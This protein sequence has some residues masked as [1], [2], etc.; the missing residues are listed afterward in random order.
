VTRIPLRITIALIAFG[1]LL[2]LLPSLS[3]AGGTLERPHGNKI[4][5]ARPIYDGLWKH[6]VAPHRKRWA[7]RVAECESGRNPDALSPGGTYRGAFQFS[8]ST[9]RSAPRSPGGDPVAYS[10]RTQAFVAVRLMTRNGKGAWP[11]CG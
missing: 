4:K 1:A 5:K 7:R 6:K 8:L 3:Q 10:Y 2:A 11:S 9:W